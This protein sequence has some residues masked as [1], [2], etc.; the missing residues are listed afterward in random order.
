MRFVDHGKR[1]P[2]AHFGVVLKKTAQAS[3]SIQTQIVC[4]IWRTIVV[5]IIILF[6]FF[7]T[8]L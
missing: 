1:L 8:K 2:W 3:I 7:F 4:T 5:I 6:L